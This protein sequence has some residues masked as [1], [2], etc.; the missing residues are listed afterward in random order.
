MLVVRSALI[1]TAGTVIIFTISAAQ[2]PLSAKQNLP[3]YFDLSSQ[4]TE[5]FRGTYEFKYKRLEFTQDSDAAYVVRSSGDQSPNTDRIVVEGGYVYW[6]LGHS[7][8]K[9][10]ALKTTLRLGDRW[11]HNLR[12][13]NQQYLV[14]A[15]DLTVS[16]PA[17]VFPHCVKVEVSWIAHEHDMDGPQKVTLYL[18]PHL[19]IIKREQWSNGQE[20]HEEVLTSYRSGTVR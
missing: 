4:L 1:L 19:G 16:V 7:G 15:T 5:E 3:L 12:G 8:E 10:V 14:V 17:G 18:A 13:W 6:V 2:L 9:W 20:W 11:Q